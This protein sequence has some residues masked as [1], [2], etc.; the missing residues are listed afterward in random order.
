[1]RIRC[2][3]RAFL[4]E[5]ES[6]RKTKLKLGFLNDSYAETERAKDFGIKGMEHRCL[7]YPMSPVSGMVSG[8]VIA[9]PA[10]DSFFI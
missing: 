5:K 8:M 7:I 4:C 2:S 3:P 6:E 10:S 1:M 9:Y